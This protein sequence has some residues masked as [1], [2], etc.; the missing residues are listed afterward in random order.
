MGVILF[1][2]TTAFYA[3]EEKLLVVTEIWPP[4]NFKNQNG[5][6]DGLSTKVITNILNRAKIEYEIKVLPWKRAYIM[7]QTK[8]NVLIYTIYRS[9]EREKLFKH[10]IGP[11][12]IPSAVYFYKLES[13]KDLLL[14]S[15]EDVNKYT[16]GV[17]R[18][19]YVEN[20]LNKMGFKQII[21]TSYFKQNVLKFL[22]KRF[23]LLP[24]GEINLKLMLDELNIDQKS[25]VKMLPLFED[26]TSKIYSAFSHG[27]NQNII[28]KVIKANAEIQKENLVKKVYVEYLSAQ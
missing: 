4:Y 5:M 3:Q 13:R 26:E 14:N 21:R 16:V 11:I 27:T 1:F 22:N 28:N 17:L 18:G 10:W 15:V 23:D 12:G 8:K 2:N 19:D 24:A 7:A 6:M 25:V 9:A 20:L